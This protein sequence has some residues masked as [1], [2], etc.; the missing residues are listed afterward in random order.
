M[1]I[2]V[3][4]KKHMFSVGE[5]EGE[6]E[7]SFADV[8]DII[9]SERVNAEEI[10]VKID[11]HNIPLDRLRELA[12]ADREGR[13]TILPYKDGTEVIA[14]LERTNATGETRCKEGQECFYCSDDCPHIEHVRR[15]AGYEKRPI[16]MRFYAPFSS[17]MDLAKRI[18]KDVFLT[19]EEADEYIAKA[20]DERE[21]AAA[22][23]EK[24]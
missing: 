16:C 7:V 5:V 18:G 19:S 2:E 21:A 6:A 15:F 4:T 22:L 13:V 8:E 9:K 12:S 14:V 17:T 1:I 11:G 3:S 23:A 20:M 10:T 24:G